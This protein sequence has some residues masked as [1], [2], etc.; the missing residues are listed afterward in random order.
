MGLKN[1]CGWLLAASFPV[2]LGACG[3]DD[4]PPKVGISFEKPDEEI[5]ESDGTPAS[6]HP[7][8]A[9]AVGFSGGVGRDITVKLTLDNAL[10]EEAVLAYTIDGTTMADN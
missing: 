10:A 3:S 1:V 7:D 4:P 9:A 6:F 5:T 8:A 2:I